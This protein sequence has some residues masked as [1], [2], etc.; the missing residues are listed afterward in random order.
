MLRF[1]YPGIKKDV[2]SEEEIQQQNHPCH[3]ADA[4][5]AHKDELCRF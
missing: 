5:Q 3:G 1:I 2:L 4:D